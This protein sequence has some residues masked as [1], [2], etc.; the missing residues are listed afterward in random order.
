MAGQRE[1]V[2]HETVM[3]VT[4]EQ[5]ARVYAKALLGA[6]N[7]AGNP[8]AVVDEMQSLAEDVLAK[9]P[10]LVELL[11]SSLVSEENKEQI[12][13]RI[14]GSRASTTVLNFVKVVARHGRLQ[15]LRPIARSLQKLYGE[16]L[17]QTEVQ[18]RVA[19]PLDDDL[20]G[21][22]LEM[23]RNALRTEPVLQIS[24][25]PSLVAGIIVRIGDRVFD[26]SVATR[27]NDLRKTIVDR[28]VERIETRP[29]TFLL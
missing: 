3:D 2:K 24:V 6:A 1:P 17:G 18:I 19:S 29:E 8:A 22:I 5:V 15:L 28:T 11:R 9:F 16:Q 14:F 10:A 23:A 25:D 20:R 26:G 21:E 4:E 13:D 27:L 7:K 12:V